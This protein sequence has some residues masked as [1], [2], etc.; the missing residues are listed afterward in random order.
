MHWVAERRGDAEVC[1]VD[2]KGQR[3]SATLK[4]ALYIPSCPQDIFSVRAATSSGATVIFK[5]GED[6]LQN[7]DGMRFPI[8]EHNRLFYL[9]TVSVNNE[10]DDQCMSCHDIQ[11][12]HEIVEHCNYDE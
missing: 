8:H 1:L 11:T 12:W 9:P 4:Q 3:L 7:K 2:G 5:E 10:C 6:V